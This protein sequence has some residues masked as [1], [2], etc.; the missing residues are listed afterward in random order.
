[1]REQIARIKKW[2]SGLTGDAGAALEP[3]IPYELS[4]NGLPVWLVCSRTRNR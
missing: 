1:M 2:L 3:E 4:L